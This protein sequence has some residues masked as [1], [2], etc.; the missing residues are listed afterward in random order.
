MTNTG[1]L[2]RRTLLAAI[3]ATV[4]A[5]G[6]AVPAHAYWRGGVFFPAPLVVIGPPPAYYAPPPAFV[7]AP[8][9]L[10]VPAPASVTPA[11]SPGT[12][13]PATPVP[14]G[15]TCYAGVYVCRL[16]ALQPAG[17]GCACPGIGALSYGSVR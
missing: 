10:A 5:I 13:G 7:Y 12:A 17:S 3:A 6:L 1:R 14:L 16:P 4:G 2:G 9:L 8:P 11:A 15:A